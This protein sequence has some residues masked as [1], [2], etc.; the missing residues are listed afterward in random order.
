MTLTHGDVSGLNRTVNVEGTM[1]SGMIETDAPINPG[2]S[3][4]PMLAEDGSVIGLIDAGNL[5]ANGIGYAVPATQAAPADRHWASGPIDQLS[6]NCDNPL[7][8]TQQQA[9]IPSSPSNSVPDSQLSGILSIFGVYFN[10]I[11]S[12]N[13]PEAFSAL[14]PDEQVGGEEAF[15]AGV[16]T[17][18]DSNFQLLSAAPVDA[19]TVKVGLAFN[20]LQASDK[21]PDGDTCDNWTLLFTMV[22]Q[23]NGGWL[24][25]PA[26]PYNGSTH[27]A[28]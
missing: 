3:G 14:T 1:R 25:G 13:Y 20:S 28:C 24:I 5:E 4:G 9:T 15:A 16:S 2:N 22:Q 6:A 10:G 17:S 11:D 12:G 18:Y 23:D 7:G 26:K 8:P 27:T 21:G 19:T